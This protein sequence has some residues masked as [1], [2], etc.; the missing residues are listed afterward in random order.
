MTPYQTKIN[1]LP[2]SNLGEIYHS[3]WRIY[4]QIEK[5]T[6][7]KPYV[8]SI[9]FKK[10]KV[11]FDFF[12]SHLKDKGPKQRFKRLKYF[13][14]AIS[15]IKNSRNKPIIKTN[16]KKGSE[17]YYRFAGLT[18]NNQ[19]FIVQIKENKISKRKYFMSCFPVE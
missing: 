6:R 15:L 14:A 7:R 5:I 8:R 13:A 3:A 16:P 2:G 19:L 17:I 9:Y 12:W 10:E 18:K 4:H 11:F 1:P